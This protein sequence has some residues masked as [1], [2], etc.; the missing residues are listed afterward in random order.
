MEKNGQPSASNKVTL[1]GYNSCSFYLK[2]KKPTETGTIGFIAPE[3]LNPEENQ[4]GVNDPK[5]D[6]WSLGSVLYYLATKHYVF[7]DSE[8]LMNENKGG[9][10]N[11]KHPYFFL[12]SKSSKI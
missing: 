10:I 8:N 11:L 1:I 5:R 2:D 6:I 7:D 9:N 12:L 3:A 4:I